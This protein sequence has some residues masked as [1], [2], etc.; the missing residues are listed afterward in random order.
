[1][2]LREASRSKRSICCHSWL[3]VR[4]AITLGLAIVE[5]M[6]G[7]VL[8]DGSF[9][10]PA[11][12]PGGYAEG[13]A[14]NSPGIG[15]YPRTPNLDFG[16]GSGVDSYSGILNPSSSSG[17]LPSLFGDQYAVLHSGGSFFYYFSVPT[18]ATY[19]LS[20]SVAPDDDGYLA[21]GFEMNPDRY[22][23]EYWAEGEETAIAVGWHERLFEFIPPAGE[24]FF[25]FRSDSMRDYDLFIDN[26]RI[27]PIPEPSAWVLLV[28][29]VAICADRVRRLRNRGLNP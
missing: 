21:W 23:D 9:E 26:I 5:V 15:F 2:K 17:D 20:F 13:A 11:L 27:T 10:T 29:G 19:Q 1:M 6:L 18:S 3:G 8:P 12:P 16:I 22:G 4:M 25:W 14:A 7:Q 28:A 24:S